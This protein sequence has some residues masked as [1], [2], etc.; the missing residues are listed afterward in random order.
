MGKLF[1]KDKTTFWSSILL[2]AQ[3]SITTSGFQTFSVQ[4]SV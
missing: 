3:E 1:T 2:T 4:V